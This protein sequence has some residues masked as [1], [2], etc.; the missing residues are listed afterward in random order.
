MPVSELGHGTVA[1]YF[2]VPPNGPPSQHGLVGNG[3]DPL[4]AIDIYFDSTAVGLVDTDN[5]G[6]FG[7]ELRAPTIG[8]MDSRY[9]YPKTRCRANTPSPP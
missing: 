7:M 8:K 5:N 3:C 6:S 4:T 9:R 2:D 1:A